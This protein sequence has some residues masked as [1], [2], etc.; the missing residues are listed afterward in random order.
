MAQYRYQYCL[1]LRRYPGIRYI[2]IGGPSYDKPLMAQFFGNGYDYIEL[3]HAMHVISKCG[4]VICVTSYYHVV[5]LLC[6]EECREVLIC[7]HE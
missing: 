5:S 7:D 6:Q 2:G 4:C 3:T 1:Y